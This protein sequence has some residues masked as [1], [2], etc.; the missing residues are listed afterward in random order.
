VSP[1][2]SN[3]NAPSASA[4]IV[5]SEVAD[6]SLS[7]TVLTGA[8]ADATPDSV[9]PEADDGVEPLPPHPPSARPRAAALAVISLVKRLAIERSS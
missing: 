6:A 2:T 4:V 5:R 8:S 3:E 9:E 1:A 7:E